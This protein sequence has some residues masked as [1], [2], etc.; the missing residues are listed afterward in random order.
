VRGRGQVR[1]AATVAAGRRGLI[2]RAQLLAVGVTP[3]VIDGLV[4]DG[5]L[6]RVHAEVY[7]VGHPRLDRE[8]RWLAATLATGGVLSHLA[9]GEIWGIL[10]PAGG[11][12]HVTRDRQGRRRPGIV[13]HESALADDEVTVRFGVPCTTL[14][15]TL[16]D[17]AGVLRPHELARAFDQA[18]VLHH[19][20]PVAL[21][22]ALLAAPGRR[23]SG[24]LQEL[25]A[26]AVD[27]GEIDSLFELRFLKFCRDFTL[28]RPATQV[29]FG[30]WTADFLFERV[31]VVV[32]TDSERWHR[33]AARRARDRRKTA[34]LEALGLTVIRVTWHELQNEPAALAARLRAAFGAS[35]LT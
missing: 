31:G 35:N 3:R 21:A 32:E 13:V 29:E 28:P 34:D 11:P 25:L 27:P 17:L 7:V 30:R 20:K 18:Q 10:R 5:W 9:A 33:T 19:L 15:R 24:R 16:I 4:E 2:T 1:R 12:V 26:D 6:H 8:A 22:A 14:T 23:G